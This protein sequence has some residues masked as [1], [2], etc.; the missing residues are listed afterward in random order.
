MTTAQ[1]Q[2]LYRIMD[3]TWGDGEDHVGSMIE[4]IGDY[5]LIIKIMKKDLTFNRYCDIYNWTELANLIICDELLWEEGIDETYIYLANVERTEA[6]I[7]KLLVS[8][9]WAID[10]TTGVA[11]GFDDNVNVL[12]HEINKK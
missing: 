10:T 2:E 5:D 8:Q 3:I 4:F 12:N 11:I 6:E 7:K 1:I 9:N